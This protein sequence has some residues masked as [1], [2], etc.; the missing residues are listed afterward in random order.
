[1][2][3]VVLV[4]PFWTRSETASYLGVAPDELLERTDVVRL[5]GRWLEETYPAFQFRDHEVRFEV[6]AIV[7][8]VGDEL[9]GTAIADWLFR[10]NPLLGAMAPIE[11]FNSGLSIKTALTAIH[12]DLED[13]K[14][15]VQPM[16]SHA[17]AS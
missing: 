13:V 3:D 17:A 6:A 14:Q 16:R 5:A 12:N 15:R 1:M 7:E 9:S 10:T 4:G 8:E 2:S 11:W